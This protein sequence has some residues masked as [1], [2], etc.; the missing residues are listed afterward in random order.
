MRRLLG[1]ALLGQAFEVQIRPAG[2]VPQPD[3]HGHRVLPGQQLAEPHQDGGLPRAHAADEQTGPACGA[4]AK[5]LGDDLGEL[6]APA[7]LDDGLLDFGESAPYLHRLKNVAERASAAEVL[8]TVEGGVLL[9]GVTFV[10]GPG[11]LMAS[12]LRPYTRAGPEPRPRS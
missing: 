4:F 10:P 6:T 5:S 8:V 2:R 3:R 1:E 12:R 7:C 11:N 9:G